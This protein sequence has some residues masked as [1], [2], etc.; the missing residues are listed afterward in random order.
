MMRT[1]TMRWEREGNN[2][3]GV[4]VVEEKEIECLYFFFFFSP[5]FCVTRSCSYIYFRLL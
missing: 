2:E 1:M 3:E 5:S 4:A